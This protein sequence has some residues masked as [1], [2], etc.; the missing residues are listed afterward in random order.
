[1]CE[2]KVSL[3]YALQGA[4]ITLVD[5]SSKQLE[6]AK[7][8]AESFNV[9]PIIKYADILQLPASFFGQY[10]ISMSFGTAEH[11]FGKDRQSIFDVHFN[12]L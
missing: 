5:Y 3:L 4:K 7:Y 8:I 1:M 11:F 9:Q 6:R 12:V 10:D 2:G